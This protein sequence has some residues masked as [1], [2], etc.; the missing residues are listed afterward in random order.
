MF[1]QLRALYLK[2]QSSSEN[3]FPEE[4]KEMKKI[5]EEFYAVSISKQ[6]YASDWF[7]HY[8][9]FF[10]MQI[11]W[12]DEQKQFRWYKDLIP[13]S[14]VF[15]LLMYIAIGILLKIAFTGGL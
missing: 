11:D 9:F 6:I 15:S 12:I 14:L 2:V 7:A 10:Q 1:N 8:K 5:M 3:T 13:K 4:E